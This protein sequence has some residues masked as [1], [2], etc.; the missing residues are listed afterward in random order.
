ATNRPLDAAVRR[1]EFRE[2][3]YYRLKVVQLEVPPLAERRDDIPDLVQHFLDES[4]RLYGTAARRLT[5]DP[6]R[7]LSANHLP[8]HVRELRNAVHGIA[9]LAKGATIE[10]GDLPDALRQQPT[11]N[12]PIALHRLPEQGER[13]L[14]LSS[15]LALRHDLREVLTI[16]RAGGPR[17]A[18]VVV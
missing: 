5:E 4:A 18:A 2:D 12:V 3:L 1:G 11:A 14:I 15:L 6:M 13:D 16:L 7:I 9:V 17:A 8:G 10:V